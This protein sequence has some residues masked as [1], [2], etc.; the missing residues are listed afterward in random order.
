MDK[1]E[2]R[3]PMWKVLVDGRACHGGEYRYSLPTDGGPGAW[4][5]QAED[6][7]VC[8][9]GY[10]L[11]TKP[12]EW[13]KVGMRVFEATGVGMYSF[14]R[15]KFA[16]ERVRLI[17]DATEEIVPGWWRKVEAFINKLSH[18]QWM[19]QHD[20]P[21]PTWRMFATR[22]Q[23]SD[24]AWDAEDMLNVLFHDASIRTRIMA[25]DHDR[26]FAH[27]AAGTAAGYAAR[28]GVRLDGAYED[29]D[30]SIASDA[31][32]DAR[33]MAYVLACDGLLLD[34]A[35]LTHVLARMDV[36]R[37]GYGLY[38]DV[39]GTLYVYRR[40]RVHALHSADVRGANSGRSPSRDDGTNAASGEG[41]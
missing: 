27:D 7:L 4:T 29:Q 31:A 1:R 5:E 16:F 9:R 21:D 8:R 40:D 39:G 35:C 36:W 22:D 14:D 17:R 32:C 28:V 11:T 18:L 12:M 2:T 10:H 37:R 24:A 30:E 19:D 23:A 41:P 3:Q 38:G 33:I 34:D 26:E 25:D 20:A 13:A 15:D 6:P